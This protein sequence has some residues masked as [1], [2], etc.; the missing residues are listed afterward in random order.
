MAELKLTDQSFET[1]VMN[2]ISCE[3]EVIEAMYGG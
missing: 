2:E 1:E 3:L